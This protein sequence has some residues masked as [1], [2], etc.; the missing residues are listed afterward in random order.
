MRKLVS[1]HIS[2]W[3]HQ[4]CR[5]HVPR[6]WL[7]PSGNILV[8]FEEIGG[9]PTQITFATR[10]MGS[11]CAHVSESHPPPVDSWNSDT[12]SERK[13]GPVLSLQCPNPDQIISSIKFA[14]F[15]TP[16]GTCGNF[17]HGLCKSKRALSILQKVRNCIT[18][19]VILYAF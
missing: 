4:S 17:N 19:I 1:S 5:Y 15:G 8:L 14:S 11:L 16:Q 18:S 7:K 12:D 9:D 10:Q 2:N 6:S 3:R 13:L